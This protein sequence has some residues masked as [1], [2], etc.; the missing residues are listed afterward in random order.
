MFTLGLMV[1]SF[2]WAMGTILGALDGKY[3]KYGSL[4]YISH[5]LWSVTP[6]IQE[7]LKL[8]IKTVALNAH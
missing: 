2:M 8:L 7:I 4:K 5:M 1:S 6:H 3:A